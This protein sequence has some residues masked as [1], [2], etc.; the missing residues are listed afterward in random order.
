MVGV[1]GLSS[2]SPAPA[3]GFRLGLTLL[4]KWSK[5]YLKVI[6]MTVMI[7][8]LLMV[9]MMMMMMMMSINTNSVLS[10][11]LDRGSLSASEST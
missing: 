4:I 8:I 3:A 5:Y 6:V 2:A 9:M 7:M 10:L 1:A 11:M